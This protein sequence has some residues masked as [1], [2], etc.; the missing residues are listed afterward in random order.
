MS[1][2][3]RSLTLLVLFGLPS[4]LKLGP[5]RRVGYQRRGSVEP[6]NVFGRG[7]RYQGALSHDQPPHRDSSMEM[8]WRWQW[9]VGDGVPVG[10]TPRVLHFTPTLPSERRGD[11]PQCAADIKL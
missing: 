8:L 4:G 2:Q 7:A 9:V 11:A 10:P 6:G 1:Y 3:S 5:T